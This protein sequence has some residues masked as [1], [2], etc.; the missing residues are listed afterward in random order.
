MFVSQVPLV[1]HI[2]PLYL[3]CCRRVTHRPAGGKT[4]L[5][6]ASND[7]N[8]RSFLLHDIDMLLNTSAW[9]GPAFAANHGQW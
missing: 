6:A 8:G 3:A 5:D 2:L 7:Q 4:D 1:S 9:V